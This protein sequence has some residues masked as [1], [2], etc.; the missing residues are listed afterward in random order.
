MFFQSLGQ[1]RFLGTNRTVGPWARDAMHGGPPC[2]L[3]AR[4]C[5][6]VQRREDTRVARITVEFLGSVPVGEVEVSAEVI[7]GGRRVELVQATMSAAGRPVLSARA[8]RIHTAPGQTAA[9]AGTPAA[10]AAPVRPAQPTGLP[11]QGRWDF[12]SYLDSLQWSSAG[13]VMQGPAA[14]WSRMAVPLVDEEEPSGLVRAVIVADSGNGISTNLPIDE[15]LFIN[16]DLTVALH[17]HPVGEWVCLDA[18]TAIDDAGIGLA[19]S[20]ISDEQ[21]ACGVGVQT[22]LVSAR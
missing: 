5:E 10:P 1:G 13:P 12:E 4:A 3:L 6:L 18:R 7:R 22:L 11:W 8:W 14:V 19:T 21:G 17:R 2:A 16:P 9:V 15:W 20:T